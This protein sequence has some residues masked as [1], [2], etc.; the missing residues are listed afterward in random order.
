[1]TTLENHILKLI[2]AKHD[3][4]F[5]E[6]E[7][8]FTKLGYGFRGDASI[9]VNDVKLSNIIIWDGWNKEYT[10]C[11]INMLANDQI[12]V[13]PTST[14]VYLIDGCTLEL[15][16]AKHIRRYKKPHWLPVVLDVA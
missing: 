16:V 12:I 9:L 1:M 11:L 3:V 8:L 7:K 4:S 14:L 13:K 5:V 2:R 15:P 10:N 6:L